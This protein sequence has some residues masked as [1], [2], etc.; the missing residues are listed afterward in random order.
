ML[1][2]P[3]R[4]PRHAGLP[5][6]R[7]SLDPL[8]AGFWVFL[9]SDL[10]GSSE[11]DRGFR[12]CAV[13]VVREPVR[14]RPPRPLQRLRDRKQVPQIRLLQLRAQPQLP[15]PRA[16]EEAAAE[17]AEKPGQPALLRRGPRP[18]EVLRAPKIRDPRRLVAPVLKKPLTRWVLGFFRV[19][20]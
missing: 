5:H 2:R 19:I 17:A 8:I 11:I 16:G 4:R 20:P 13:E 6:D 3:I 7:H 14:H 15:A 1:L 12:V 10:K 18:V 9:G